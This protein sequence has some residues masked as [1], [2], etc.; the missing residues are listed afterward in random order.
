[1]VKASKHKNPHLTERSIRGAKA[2]A[3]WEKEHPNLTAWS[4]LPS[5]VVLGT[6][7]APLGA[8]AGSGIAT[9]GDAAAATSAGQAITTGLTPLVTAASTNVAGAPLYTW[10]DAVLSSIFGAHG[11][12]TAMDEGGV[13][14]TTALEIAPLG[15]LAKPMWNAGKE[16]AYNI[17]D[18]YIFMP[19]P[20]SFTRGIGMTDAG[21]QD[22]VTTGVFRGN[23]RG[24][25]V[26]AKQFTKL[27]ERNRDNFRDIMDATGIE[28]IASKFQSRTL[29][30]TEFNAIKEA[31]KKYKMKRLSFDN[32]NISPVELPA[33]P[34]YEYPDY[35]SYMK[36]VNETI[37]NVEK[38]PSR[39]ASG[40][41]KVNTELTPTVDGVPHGKPIDER[42]GP[43]SDYVG[44]GQPLSYWYDDGRNPLTRGH[45]YAKSNYGVRVN[46]LEDYTPFMHE[47]HLHPSFF[48]TPQ[49]AD[50]NVE[51]FGKGPLGLTVKL[52]KETLQPV[53]KRDLS[54]IFKRGE[55][56]IE[57]YRYPIGRPQVPENF[58][59][60][61]PQV[62]TK[63]GD[64][65]VN[66]PNMAY[67]QG[68]DLG[69]TYQKYKD[70]DASVAQHQIED[71]IV[72]SLSARDGKPYINREVAL[73]KAIA[74]GTFDPAVGIEVDGHPAAFQDTPMYADGYLW[75]GTPKINEVLKS[76]SLQSGLLVTPKN[77]AFI[78]G[79][80]KAT[81]YKGTGSGVVK[82]KSGITTVTDNGGRLIPADTDNLG[83]ELNNISAYT[84]EPGYGYRKVMKEPSTS[85]KFFERKPA[86]ISEAERFGLNKHDRKALSENE[87]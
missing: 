16:T 43:N 35:A 74:D 40:E 25:E 26:T 81:P 2:H 75:Y 32:G 44:D 31:A 47:L 64:V 11:I 20:N 73:D 83:L 5:A 65:E 84:W 6:A 63:V 1:M 21:L 50:P 27:F 78:I 7:L 51:I 29:S 49:L 33:D 62:R 36:S 77:D 55:T 30:E 9:L 72:Q 69:R 3:A 14:P 42:F 39:I 52:D 82:S 66:T 48:K 80:N 53:W 70:V 8:T 45:S 38:M 41:I 12:Q 4:Y 85:L 86:N 60:V 34:L 18:R 79:S 10:A 71:N 19:H 15:R 58:L 76:G 87:Q 28:G 67:R 23:P 37:A 57:N 17:A 13:S 24:T 56:A 46:N 22:A 68:N 61:K 59:T 54:N